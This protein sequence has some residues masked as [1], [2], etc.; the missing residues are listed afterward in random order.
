MIFRPLIS[1]C[2]GSPGQMLDSDR[3]PADDP[4]SQYSAAMS[5]SKEAAHPEEQEKPEVAQRPDCP[6]KH[7]LSL[8]EISEVEYY[9]DSCGTCESKGAT[10]FGCRACNYDLCQSCYEHFPTSAQPLVSFGGWAL[11]QHAPGSVVTSVAVSADSIAT[12]NTAGDVCYWEH[13]DSATCQVLSGH[14]R[15]VYSVAFSPDGQRLVSGGEDGT[16]RLWSCGAQQPPRRRF[17][18]W[19][20]GTGQ[21][22]HVLRGHR[23]LVYSVAF[24]ADGQKLASG[25]K[26]NTTKVW[27]SASG[28]LLHTTKGH[29]DDVRA[30]CFSPDG[31]LATGS[32][33]NTIRVWDV[34]TG[35]CLLTLSIYFDRVFSVAF[36]KDGLRLA[37]GSGDKSVRVWD[38]KTGQILQTLRGHL[39][40]VT[41]VVFLPDGRLA[42][43]SYEDKKVLVWDPSS[44]QCVE[45]TG[46]TDFV[47]CLA[48]SPDGTQLFGAAGSDGNVRV[49]QL[50]PCALVLATGMPKLLSQ[51]RDSPPEAQDF[52]W[53][54]YLSHRP[55]D[56]TGVCFQALAAHGRQQSDGKATTRYPP[57]CAHASTD[58]VTDIAQSAAFVAFCTKTYFED[59]KCIAELSV[60]RALA[61]PVI[62]VREDEQNAHALPFQDLQTADQAIVSHEVVET[63][64]IYARGFVN[65]LAARVELAWSKRGR[66]PVSAAGS[67][68]DSK[69]QIDQSDAVLEG[70]RDR[71]SAVAC[72][73]DGALVAS[74]S[75]DS[76]TSG[77]VDSFIMVWD[78][79]SHQSLQVLQGH[80]DRVKSVAFSPDGKRLASG[81]EDKSVRVWDLGTGRSQ[82]LRKHTRPVYSV[83]F[84]Q[85][86]TLLASGSH[87]MSICLWRVETGELVRLLQGHSNWVMSVAFSED[88]RQLASGSRDKSVRLWD[89]QTGKAIRTLQGHSEWVMSV[90]FS[91]LG[92]LASGSSDNSI[93]LWNAE[94]GEEQAVLR[95]HT[96]RVSSVAWSSDGKRLASAS[97]DKTV[98]I[99]EVDGGIAQKPMVLK[100]HSDSVYS[101]AFLDQ[102]RLVSG[103]G[104]KTV[105]LWSINNQAW[106]DATTMLKDSFIKATI[107]EYK[108]KASARPVTKYAFISHVQKEAGDAAYLLNTRFK[109]DRNMPVWHDKEAGRLDLL[110][111]IQGIADSAVFLPI[112]T[113]GY[114]NSTWCMVELL[115]ARALQK[116]ELWVREVDPRFSPM[117]L[118]KL[119][120][121]G[122]VDPTQVIETNR[123]Y[124][125]EFVELVV[126]RVEEQ[127]SKDHHP[128][129]KKT[130]DVDALKSAKAEAEA[131]KQRREEAEAK[132]EAADQAR[133]EAEAK[134]ES[135]K[136]AREEAEA[137]LEAVKKLADAK[138]EALQAE[139]QRMRQ[140]L[141]QSARSPDAGAVALHISPNPTGQSSSAVVGSAPSSWGEFGKISQIVPLTCLILV[142]ILTGVTYF[143][144]FAQKSAK[145]LACEIQ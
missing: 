137:R 20:R 126:A 131:E 28:R 11:C 124:Y 2:P 93:R 40:L 115:V 86:G 140:E 48:L 105:R 53:S 143:F 62:C 113:N 109:F 90:A 42:S 133:E 111:M 91:K 3:I 46:L 98:S 71:V 60:A 89:V 119:V 84:S 33:D 56:A 136:K 129:L 43:A 123:T 101:V 120:T 36:S 66:Q 116:H 94:T 39:G 29:G 118:D 141:A 107:E 32:Y 57:L 130:V 5:E 108:A 37:S 142:A 4:A 69:Q 50:E 52:K 9:C 80:T 44:E 95:G 58:W 117:S 92:Q 10:M 73:S 81:S 65:K 8:F 134:M 25:S 114:F 96:E 77:S 55:Q 67:Q 18:L 102:K 88:G 26:D 38:A 74:G 82:E 47:H 72:S 145:N 104:D 122:G 31:R 144:N 45:L 6:G 22:L 21:A 85:D 14:T 76:I 34:Q 27:D 121:E 64:V 128:Q 83:A 87:D 112:A 103:S 7:S 23:D 68:Q 97:W 17:R 106:L 99:W 30:V 79:Q 24:S 100:G 49:W 41:S 70:H 132:M 61:K 138:L 75:V 127:A 59:A 12:G 35:K 139:L 63:H 110:G 1:K 125:N 135:E 13:A 19:G 54:A 15:S 51:H 16:V 78:A